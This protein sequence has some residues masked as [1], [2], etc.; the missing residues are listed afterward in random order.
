MEG[1]FTTFQIESQFHHRLGSFVAF[2][3]LV[4]LGAFT[5]FSFNT[6]SLGVLLLLSA[7][8]AFDDLGALVSFVA[9]GSFVAFGV[10]VALGAFD[11]FSFSIRSLFKYLS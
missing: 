11:N 4:D 3:D 7:F 10:L 9:L 8:C 5:D 1:C 2:G 6:R